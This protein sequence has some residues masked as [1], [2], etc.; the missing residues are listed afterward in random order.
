MT[1]VGLDISKWQGK[2]TPATVAAMVGQG[3]RFCYVKVS[4][5]IS[6]EDP[7][8][9]NSVPLLQA[10]GILVGPYHFVTNSRYDLQ[11]G[12]F[13]SLIDQTDWDLIPLLDCEAYTSVG[14]SVYSFREINTFP[15]A[16][17]EFMGAALSADLQIKIYSAPA[18]GVI[19]SP[20]FALSYPTQAIVDGMGR[21]ITA[22]MTTR[23]K[24]APYLYPSIYTN[25]SSGNKIFTSASMSRYPLD[26]ANWGV[27]IPNKP[28]VWKNTPYYAWQDGVVAGQP[29]GIDGK[30]DHQQWGLLFDFPGD[31]PEPPPPPEQNYIDLAGVDQNGNKWAGRLVEDI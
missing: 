31:E 7:Q 25:A 22:W 4:Q 10:G 23:P 1:I 3:V 8:W 5:D 27:T 2:I 13:G 6:H 21:S 9:R 11:W 16:K 24:L 26:V 18:G 28:A 15:K 17:M 30:V 14:G 19:V 12:W 20:I 29:Y